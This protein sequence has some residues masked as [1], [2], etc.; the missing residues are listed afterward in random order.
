MIVGNKIKYSLGSYNKSDEKEQHIRITEGC[1]NNCPYCYEPKEIKVFDIPEIIRNDVKVMDMNLLCKSEAVSIIEH[2]GSQKVNNKVVYYSLICG[3][4]WRFL[5]QE[6]ADAL[7]RN[8]FGKIRLAWDFGFAHQK[9]VK[10]AIEMLR[11][12]GYKQADDVMVFMVCNW[13]TSFDVNMRKLDL[14][15]VWRCQASDCWFDNQLSP[16]VQPVYWTKEQIKIFRS[17]CR[18]HNQL[19]TFGIDPEYKASNDTQ[20]QLF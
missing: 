9:R 5:T 6:L 19:V 2:L 20:E 4:D 8:R 13:K 14:L 17:K 11:K 10:S 7:H 1:P 12:A 15:K 18:K 16:N 3:I